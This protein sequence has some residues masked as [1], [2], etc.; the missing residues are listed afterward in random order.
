M[1]SRNKY[2]QFPLRIN[3]IT[4]DKLKVIASE[5]SRST[6]KEMEYALNQY[7]KNYEEINGEITQTDIDRLLDNLE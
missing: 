7:V 2:P 6:N 4:I 1:P 5:N 3:P